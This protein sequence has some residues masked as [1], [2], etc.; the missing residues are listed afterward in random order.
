MQS[1][2]ISLSVLHPL[3]APQLYIIR[4]DIMSCQPDHQLTVYYILVNLYWHV[5]QQNELI[6]NLHL[7]RL[8][9]PSRGKWLLRSCTAVLS[10]LVHHKSTWLIASS[11]HHT[12]RSNSIA[13]MLSKC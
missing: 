6:I 8:L 11:G 2:V 3:Y 9:S 7:F 4:S 1:Q 13:E 12:I 10:A 5:P